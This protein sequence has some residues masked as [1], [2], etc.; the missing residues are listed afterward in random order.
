M[1]LLSESDPFVT[2]RGLRN[3][4]PIGTLVKT[5][6]RN[7]DPNPIFQEL[8]DLGFKPELGDEL[9]IKIYDFD[10]DGEEGN[11]IKETRVDLHD[12]HN[13]KARTI[14]LCTASNPNFSVT[15]RWHLVGQVPPL[16][17][18]IFIVRHGESKWNEAQSALVCIFL[19]KFR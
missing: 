4:H 3:G 12:L 15:L 19:S 18:T 7:D 1:D 10:R 9:D 17:K 11:L 16:K 8:H 6:H 5:L 14:P 13:G 2:V